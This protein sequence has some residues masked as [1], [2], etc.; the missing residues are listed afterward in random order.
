MRHF[1]LIILLLIPALKHAQAT[2]NST[3]VGTTTGQLSVSL[4]GSAEYDIPLILP[5][6]VNG[7]MPKLS[8][9]YSSNAGNDFAGYGWDISGV[10]VIKKVAATPFH[11]NMNDGVDHDQNDR[12]SLDGQRLLLN[13]A[14][15]GPYGSNNAK[16]VTE[17]HSN[18][19]VTSYKQFEWY[20]VQ[21]FIVKYPD[22][23]IAQYG[24]PQSSSNTHSEYPIQYW[25]N[26]LGQR[27]TY[28]YAETGFTRT[29]VSIKYGSAVGSETNVINFLYS[30][31][32]R[33][34][35]SYAGNSLSIRQNLLTQIEIITNAVGFK[36][37]FLEYDVNSLGYQRLVKL[38]EKTG[39]QSL[40]YNPTVFSYDS[41]SN[42]E[43]FTAQPPKAI[44]LSNVDYE[45]YRN[46]SGDFD[47]NGSTDVILFPTTG[48]EPNSRYWLY[49]NSQASYDSGIFHDVGFFEDI[50]PSSQLTGNATVGY[51]IA[52]R[53][54]WVV[55]KPPLTSSAV[56]FTSYLLST[57][58][59]IQEQ[60]IKLYSFP[61]F[62]VNTRAIDYSGSFL[63]HI[64]PIKKK[65]I[66][67]DFNGDGLTDILAIEPVQ[68]F[69]VPNPNGSTSQHTYNGST[70][71]V[72][73]DKRLVN[74]FANIAAQIKISEETNQIAVG[75]VNGD[76]KSDLL[77]FSNGNV[78]VYTLA[79]NNTLN[80]LFETS[81]STIRI[82]KLILF[83]DFNGD[84]LMDFTIP[85]A[86]NT[87]DWRFF[88]STGSGYLH[89]LQALPFPYVKSTTGNHP[90]HGLPNNSVSLREYAYIANDYN[91]D[92]KTDI[93]IQQNLTAV[94]IHTSNGCDDSVN[95]NPMK[96]M[97]GIME[98]LSVDATPY[99][100]T[101]TFN[102]LTTT[103]QVTGVKKF[104]IPIFSKNSD[105][106]SNLE[107]TLISGNQIRSFKSPKDNRQDM[108]LRA[109]T[110]G[111]G[112]K[113]TITYEALKNVKCRGG[114][115]CNSVYLPSE[116]SQNYPNVDILMAPTMN[117]VTRL[118]VFGTNHHRKQLFAYHGAV[119]NI[120]G[121]GF[122]GF[123][124]LL[125]TNWFGTDNQN[126]ISN[127]SINDPGLRGA[128]VQNYSIPGLV[129]PNSISYVNYFSK[130]INTYNTVDGIFQPPLQSSKVYK[131]QNTRIQQFNSLL[132]ISTD[133][134]IKY[135][136]YNNPVQTSS[137]I[138]EGN[139][140]VQSKTIDIEYDNQPTGTTYIIGRTLGKSETSTL[141]PGQGVPNQ[142]TTSSEELYTYEDNLL[143]QI[144]QKGYNTDYLVENREYD[145]F[146]NIVRKSVS[147]P[148]LAARTTTFKF[149]AAAPNYGRFPTQVAIEE[150]GVEK[151]KHKFVYTAEGLL[152]EEFDSYNNKTS[153]IYDK[154]FKKTQ[155]ID[156][157]YKNTSITYTKPDQT[158]VLISV[159][160]DDGS[161]AIEKFDN[162]GRKV[163][164][165]N[166]L[167]DNSWSFIKTEY[168]IHGDP[169]AVSQPYNDLNGLPSQWNN[170]SYNIHKQIT[171]STEYTGK[172]I[173]IEYNG[174][175]TTVSDVLKTVVTTKNAVGNT[176]Q[177]TE[178]SST[179]FYKYYANGN[180]KL[181]D[182]GSSEIKIQQDGW[183]R[184]TKL[185]D[186]SS[187][188]YEYEY[189]HFGELT[190]EITPNGVTEYILSDLG[191]IIEK[192]VVGINTNTK[193]TYIYDADTKQ[194]KR[195]ENDDFANSFETNYTFGYDSYGR[196]NF[197]DENGYLAYFQQ[198][199][200]FDNYG[201]PSRELFTAINTADNKRSDKWIKNTYKNGH[202]W[203][204]VDDTSGKVLWQITNVNVN[205]QVVKASFG[206]V[207]RVLTVDAAYD[208][209][210]FPTAIKYFK[211]A[212]KVLIGDPPVPEINYLTLGYSFNAQTG[213][214]TSRSNSHF[215]WDESFQYDALDRLTHYTGSNG[216]QQEQEYD[217][218]GRITENNAG[219]YNYSTTKPYRNTSVE[220]NP[221]S[222]SYYQNREGVFNDGMESQSGWTTY[223]HTAGTVI[224]DTSKSKTG[225]YSL[226]VNNVTPNPERTV[227]SEIWIP[228]ENSVATSYTYSVWVY[229]DG[230]Q[231]EMFMFMS[232]D[233]PVN[234]QTPIHNVQG[235]TT[236]QWYLLQG[237]YIVPAGIK[238]IK[239]RVDNN[240]NGNVWF[241]DV[242]LRKTGTTATPL[243]E[244][245]ISYNAHK[246]PVQI[247][248]TGVDKISF[249][250]NTAN[251]RTSMF[252]GGLES[253]KLQRPLRK[254]YSLDGTME[255]KYNTVSG[256]TEFITYIGGDGYSAPVALKSNGTDE[257]YLFL[258]RDYQGSIM[259]IY[260]EQSNPLEHRLYDAWG[261]LVEVRDGAGNKIGRMTVLDRGY[262]GHEHLQSV[263]LVHM[264]GR[265]YDPVLHRFLQ[266]DNDI[267]DPFNTQNYNRYGYVMNNP[268]KYTDP[269][270]ENYR[271]GGGEG[272]AG[273]AFAA[274]SF[275]GNSWDELG[276]KDGWN[277]FEGWFS[278]NA[279]SVGSFLERNWN[280][281]FGSKNSR[282]IS[283]PASSASFLSRNGN[284]NEFGSFQSFS[285]ETG[286]Q[287]LVQ[288][289]PYVAVTA[290]QESSGGSVGQP[291]DL[292][293]M[294]PFW[295]SGRAS[296][297]H[298]QNGN[299]WRGTGY[300]L[301]AISD[302]FLVKAAFTVVA[303][304]TITGASK[305]ALKKAVA[306]PMYVGREALHLNNARVGAMMKGKGIDRAFRYYAERN[307]VIKGA[308]KM[309]LLGIN[310][311]NRG[312]DMIGKGILNGVWWDVTTFKSWQNHVFKYG[313]G[314]IGLFY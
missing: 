200:Q 261:K 284:G 264:N 287:N 249:T 253:D 11:D 22:G 59:V 142:D 243:R 211:P 267:Q 192:T 23:S 226:K 250:Y 191:E 62:N 112:K 169:T 26:S 176:I 189:N 218:R 280:S 299:Y 83:G 207:G 222:E 13:P 113:E 272:W 70:Y 293:S 145:S 68:K 55:I 229:S 303:K 196:L 90:G 100:Q 228:V 310:P 166:K 311:T 120:N 148:G 45:K 20:D 95:G 91:G 205:G 281:V 10:S 7:V 159:T 82:D 63:N 214:L 198:A 186:P 56:R 34:E 38:Y 78:K 99:Q 69:T 52:Q 96:T 73:L 86:L 119:A 3:Q 50:L 182:Y 219:I 121:L 237:T 304:G 162:L 275:I 154:W 1:Y 21:Y 4:T 57:S 234:P 157:L 141:Y 92:G 270:G 268:L 213:N 175:A 118:E 101:Y 185:E 12:F 54:G 312:A 252:Y 131:L 297:D 71:F 201:R 300:A 147:A 93:L 76:G 224:Y 89:K 51:K 286:S 5:P 81:S 61:H 18:I 98:N 170:F 41:T 15:T 210:G 204:T 80:V 212:G 146:G 244:L 179:I 114:S 134:N 288:I 183:G 127:I 258:F 239:L 259:A 94:C 152:K 102:L 247:E 17:S 308:Q 296:V 295:G 254:F 257:E 116:A 217:P 188:N 126:I 64:K 67:G 181:T 197:K 276:I 225:S 155:T 74:S 190:K 203:Q 156:D 294:I 279:K 307:I 75:D 19:V 206:S 187:G 262:T 221:A 165:G 14:E 24:N 233:N 58:N 123:R 265:L 274:A 130:S 314:G 42:S 77:I 242:R 109:I 269:S 37:Y 278:K 137:I 35:V 208:E 117:V 195:I 283:F 289:H 115:Y 164:T 251:G 27:I 133:T 231:A 40:A 173:N 110:Y 106:N 305:F 153:Y 105:A 30:N 273:A 28:Q 246:S 136:E 97:F 177:M 313:E 9:H 85:N 53:Q 32:V 39:D 256:K 84:G 79:D 220:L 36:N 298:F 240:G 306:N 143:T 171:Q 129:M 223:Y 193:D 282:E 135:D 285:I 241:D 46:I 107:Y 238:K 174:L 104:P 158:T 232:N 271:E 111:D 8:L 60:D 149:D 236:G 150:S 122:L 2:G 194:L 167:I 245:N 16:Y 47:G 125:R 25:E 87:Y 138:R 302:V 132:N 184:K 199:T 151:L 180:L 277:G 292:E 144:K 139:V 140:N 248:E 209:Y 43:L 124:G 290:G 202:R 33:P 72:N 260:D 227:E 301:W 49:N 309:G 230:P 266:P 291:G 31:R 88:T 172:I 66:S 215:A 103:P 48:S 44:N 255:I 160:K 263:G 178:G 161:A 108:L 65:Y 6:G 216:L 168:N 163:I 29:L 128:N 235:N